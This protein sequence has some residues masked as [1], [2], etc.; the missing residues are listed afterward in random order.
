[1]TEAKKETAWEEFAR[2]K[3]NYDEY[4]ASEKA[5]F[6]NGVVNY[7]SGAN[8]VREKIGKATGDESAGQIPTGIDQFADNLLSNIARTKTNLDTHFAG[9]LEEI[10]KG[11]PTDELDNPEVVLQY[12]PAKSYGAIAEAHEKVRGL[13]ERL[14]KEPEK[15]LQELH[16]KKKNIYMENLKKDTPYAD[17]K[18]IESC[19]NLTLIGMDEKYLLRVREEAEEEFAKAFKAGDSKAYATEA[20]ANTIKTFVKDNKI[21]L[22]EE[23]ASNPKFLYE[24]A[25][26]RARKAQDK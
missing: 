22:A 16:E 26:E 13:A 4:R 3:K 19:A 21:D 1:M 2:H 9:N 10:V 6:P 20:L 17:P 5:M 25:I 14:Q 24:K 12:Q 18:T 11:A 15:V 7:L 23:L 8:Q